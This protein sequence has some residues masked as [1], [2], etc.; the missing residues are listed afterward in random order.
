MTIKDIARLSG[1]SVS[2][3]SRALNDHPDVSDEAKA[4]VRE[5]V[6]RQNFVPNNSA[7]RLSSSSSNDVG[8]IVRGISN[9]FY[10]GVIPEIERSIRD[11]G[12]TLVMQQID[13]R[14][15][16]LQAGAVM[17]RER[18]LLGII[19]LGGRSDYSPEEIAKVTVPHVFCTFDN[20]YGTLDRQSYSSVAIDDVET[21]RQ[22]VMEL[23]R[24]GHRRIAMMAAC[25]ED[26]SVSQL[27]YAGYRKAL[28][29][30]G[31]GEDPGLVLEAGGYG[32]S[33]GYRAAKEWLEGGRDFT[34]LFAASDNLAIG[35][36][37]AMREKGLRV[38][39]DVSVL[40]VDGLE[41]A[42]YMNPTI[43][44]FCQPVR[45]IG[46]KTAGILAGVIRGDCANRQEVLDTYFKPGGSVRQIGPA[47]GL[48][49]G[50]ESR[51][52]A[53]TA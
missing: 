10:T 53:A 11:A 14:A 3:V 13:A 27:R 46:A 9:P 16:E 25:K 18:R 17:Q 4:R 30:L 19:F 48:A 51:K 43:A 47:A 42:D 41:V 26:A 50:M 2:T 45:E 28:G 29:E 21:G 5:V 39:E 40:S 44:T 38:P 20:S 12:Y 33:D 49:F 1:V 35:A 8:L 22:A 31:I 15:D 7:R 52:A 24:S 32:L 36:I 34:A 6:A 37:R 23:C